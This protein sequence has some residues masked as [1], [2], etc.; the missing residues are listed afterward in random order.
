MLS[1][2]TNLLAQN[3]N[4]NLKVNTGK[5]AKITEKLSSGYKINRA[6][7]DASGLSMSEKMRRQVRGLHQSEDNIDEGVGYVQTAEGA[8]SEVQDILQRINQLSVKAANGTNTPEDRAYIDQEIQQL[9]REMSRIFAETT[10]NTRKIWDYGPGEKLDYRYE[11]AVRFTNSSKSFDVTNDN[12]GVI[13]ADKYSVHADKSGVWVT[14]TGFDTEKY[15]T[16]KVDWDYLESNSYT[17]K[18]EDYFGEKV[19]DN[20]LYSHNS[21]TGEYEPVFTK[22]VSFEVNSNPLTTRQHVID[23]INN[24]SMSAAQSVSMSV[25]TNHSKYF[26][27]S[28]SVKS[29]VTI[30]TPSLTYPAAYLSWAK[31]PDTDG[32]DFDNR[33]D[34]FLVPNPA[35]GNLTSFPSTTNV[36]TAK[37]SSAGWTFT[38][39][40]EGIGEVTATSTGSSFS[41]NDAS[42]YEPEDEDI[43]WEWDK[44]WDG[45]K[46]VPYQRT[47]GK[48]GGGTLGAVM[49][50]LTGGSGLLTKTHNGWSDRGGNITISFSITPKDKTLTYGTGSKLTSIGSF[51]LSFP[52]KTSDTE[53]SVL[54]RIN[55]ALNA[56]T[57]LDFT[58]T[59]SGNDSATIYG[60]RG[61]S[62]Y[63]PIP[64]YPDDYVP[65]DD[66]QNFFVQAGT[67]SGQHISIKYEFLSVEKLG[68]EDTNTLT[69]ES[70]ERA[71]NEV[72]AALQIVSKQRSDFGAYQNRLEHAYNINANV[73]EN[74]Q[75][76]ESVIR[77]TD[78]AEMIMEHSVN[79][80]LMQAGTSML[81]QANQSKQSVL[82]L[83][84]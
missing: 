34:D 67:E 52:V 60:L 5:N 17:F 12:C 63:V 46:Y 29:E 20:S 53:Q 23:S 64:V 45:T 77:D 51:S 56:N 71:I 4:R 16:T 81:T 62:A 80:I 73:E 27:N 59:G 31:S 55:A 65:Y 33:D 82:E 41:S 70:A 6:A 48:S 39:E 2:Q 43:W 40:M 1:V 84:N 30:G 47:L 7:D 26:S 38:F 54:D 19:P 28:T 68:M 57:V 50:G 42:Y 25:D 72:K 49:R 75:S 58:T 79:N 35:N 78:I 66:T 37:N 76:S 14:W 21:A 69:Q 24:S 3:A 83:L 44:Y 11:P 13:A 74:T 10:F 9:K 22:T 15:T 36:A 61:S 32:H 8:L 18:M